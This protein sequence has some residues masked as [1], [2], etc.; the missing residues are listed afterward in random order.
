MCEPPQ[1]RRQTALAA[2]DRAGN[3]G[4]RLEDERRRRVLDRDR[5]AAGRRRH[6]RASGKAATASKRTVP[7]TAKGWQAKYR[8]HHPRASRSRA[9]VRRSSCPA[10]LDHLEVL[11]HDVRERCR[12]PVLTTMRTSSVWPMLARAAPVAN[13]ARIWLVEMRCVACRDLFVQRAACRSRPRFRS[14]NAQ[15]QNTAVRRAG[16]R[17][18]VT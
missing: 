10:A 9:P 3:A 16:A 5:A 8:H 4:K 17:S 18:T 7:A 14:R 2:V 12:A 6:D 13:D 1:D 11:Q 15:R